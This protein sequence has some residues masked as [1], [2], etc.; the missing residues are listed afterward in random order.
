[1]FVKC[2]HRQEHHLQI[3]G[4]KRNGVFHISNVCKVSA[5]LLVLTSSKED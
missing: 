4:F 5:G 1:M 2:D 3:V